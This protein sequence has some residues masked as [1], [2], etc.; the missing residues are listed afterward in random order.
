MRPAQI[1]LAAA[2]CSGCS[3]QI[4]DAR[5]PTVGSVT[6]PDAGTGTAAPAKGSP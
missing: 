5:D 2:L 1:A 6:E 3:A 4:S